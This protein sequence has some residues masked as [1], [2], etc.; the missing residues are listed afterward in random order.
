MTVLKNKNRWDQSNIVYK[1]GDIV[2]YDKKTCDK[3]AEYID[4][5]LSILRKSAFEEIGQKKVPDLVELYKGLIQKKQLL[6]FEVKNRFY[7]IGSPSGLAETEK[8]LLK[9]SQNKQGSLKNRDAEFFSR[10]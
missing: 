8:Y 6:G 1:N 5:G 3:K 10:P 4:Y 7:E 2:S 9:L